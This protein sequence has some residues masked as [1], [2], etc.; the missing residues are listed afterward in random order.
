[1]ANGKYSEIHENHETLFKMNEQ[2]VLEDKMATKLKKQLEH[3]KVVLEERKAVSSK[4]NVFL[5]YQ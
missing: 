2:I 4:F 1:M 5:F 3:E